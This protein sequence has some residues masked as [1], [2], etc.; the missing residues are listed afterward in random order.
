MASP[1]QP[2]KR[3]FQAYEKAKKWL[4]E[5]WPKREEVWSTKRV[6]KC[7]AKQSRAETVDRN[8]LRTPSFRFTHGL[9]TCSRHTCEASLRSS[10]HQ[11]TT[12]GLQNTCTMNDSDRT[13]GFE[14]K[15]LVGQVSRFSP[16]VLQLLL[17]QL[18]QPCANR[19]PLHLYRR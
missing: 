19:E 15:R 9:R 14:S 16:A 12:F 3:P 6:E 5:A 11:P 1:F 18:S 17:K 13:L 2:Q 7:F 10:A 8:G 4:E